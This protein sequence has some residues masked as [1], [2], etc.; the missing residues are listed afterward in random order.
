[1]MS[2]IR[3]RKQSVVFQVPRPIVNV[4]CRLLTFFGG[5]VD[6]LSFVAKTLFIVVYN[7]RFG[8]S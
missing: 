7:G 1:M 8:S 3:P 4:W 2:T 6:D 5:Y